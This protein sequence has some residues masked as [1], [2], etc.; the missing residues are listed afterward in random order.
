M[1]DEDDYL[2]EDFEDYEADGGSG[3]E[4]S[5]ALEGGN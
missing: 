4:E 5:S 2:D 1:A 3:K